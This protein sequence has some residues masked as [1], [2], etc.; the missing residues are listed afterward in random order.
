MATSETRKH[1]GVPLSSSEKE[2]GCSQD[3]GGRRLAGQEAIEKSGTALAVELGCPA[4]AFIHGTTLEI[5]RSMKRSEA[6]SPV[7]SSVLDSPRVSTP[8]R[9]IHPRTNQERAHSAA[10]RQA[11]CLVAGVAVAGN[12]RLCGDDLA[13]GQAVD[14]L[15]FQGQLPPRQGDDLPLRHG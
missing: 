4:G 3:A 15:T 11:E 2:R 9:P 12:Q 7:V 10:V 8:P 5:S 6:K 1:T 14:W 13:V